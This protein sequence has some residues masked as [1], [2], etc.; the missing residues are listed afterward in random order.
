[1]KLETSDN[2]RMGA[3]RMLEV[4]E[5]AVIVP[6]DDATGDRIKAPIGN[7]TIGCGRNTDAKPLKADEIVYL[8]D[9]D[10]DDAVEDCKA[11]LGEFE[12][13][14]LSEIHQ[15]AMINMAFTLGR[16]GLAKFENMI[17]AIKRKEFREAA[18]HILSSKWFSQAP[19]RVFRVAEML[20]SEQYPS[21]YVTGHL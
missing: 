16:A 9:N 21:Y 2:W 18:D 4:E 10:I 5:G 7:V 19:N 13:R 20:R 11:V 6:Y 14:G 12:Y 3:R 17:D 1:M 15:Y 8:L